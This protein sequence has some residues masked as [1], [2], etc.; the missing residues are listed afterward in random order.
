MAALQ[1]LTAKPMLFVANVDEGSDE[2]P[3]ELVEHARAYGAAVVALSARLEAELAELDPHEAAAMRAD[4]GLSESGLSRVVRGAFEL[5]DLVAFFTAGE[6]N[7]AQSWHLRRGLSVWHAAGMVHS[8]IQRG[9]VRAEVVRGMSLWTPGGTP[10]PVTA[11][12]SGWRDGTTW[13]PTG[14][15]SQCG[16]RRNGLGRRP[17]EVAPR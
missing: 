1:P 14:T 15:S 3:A 5:L 6:D 11:E 16:S 13:S 8:D 4:L 2:V 12:R 7:P 10:A 9:F 17:S